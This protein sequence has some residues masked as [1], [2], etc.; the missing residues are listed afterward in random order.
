MTY[1]LAVNSVSS[2]HPK[3]HSNSQPTDNTLFL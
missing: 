1:F 2:Q 3:Q